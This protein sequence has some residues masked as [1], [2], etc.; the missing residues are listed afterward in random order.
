MPWKKSAF[1]VIA[2]ARK[3]VKP[4]TNVTA[5]RPVRTSTTNAVATPEKSVTSS[6]G[7]A[8][9]SRSNTKPDL[10]KAQAPI[11]ECRP[12]TIPKSRNLVSSP[13]TTSSMTT[14][15]P[16]AVVSDRKAVKSAPMQTP[17]SENTPSRAPA[18]ATKQP[19]QMKSLKS[20]PVVVKSVLQ[21]VR[22][23][24]TLAKKGVSEMVAS[25]RQVN[26]NKPTPAREKTLGESSKLSS[27]ET[28]ATKQPTQRESLASPPI[29][30]LSVPQPVRT[31]GT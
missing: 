20:P 15:S 11:S 1:E 21:P 28:L 19:A 10:T 14:T 12:D 18:S 9:Q 25:S 3:T 31:P 4:E 5:Q 24:G 17:M 16:A 8:L 13:A 27:R 26:A 30:T 22:T 6:S 23:P 2:S 7:S 29:V